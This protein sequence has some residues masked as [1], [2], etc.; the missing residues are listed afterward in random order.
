MKIFATTETQ[1]DIQ[2]SAISWTGASATSGVRNFLAALYAH[3]NGTSSHWSIKS[4]TASTTSATGDGGFIIKNTAGVEICFANGYDVGGTMKTNKCPNVFGDTV[5]TYG[6]GGTYTQN[7]VHLAIAPGGGVSA[8]TDR[9]TQ[10]ASATRFS[11]WTRAGGGDYGGLYGASSSYAYAKIVETPNYV[12]IRKH[13]V[14]GD[15]K[16]YNIG[17]FAG[18][19]EAHGNNATG[20]FIACAKFS[21]WTNSGGTLY[22]AYHMRYESSSNGHWIACMA[23]PPPTSTGFVSHATYT[24]NQ[25]PG[26][27]EEGSPTYN[28]Y[29][30][31]IF[32]TAYESTSPYDYSFVGY[33]PCILVG[34]EGNANPN[35]SS[36]LTSLNYDGSTFARCFGNN[37]QACWFVRDD[38]T[39]TENP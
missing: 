6:A 25:H 10:I 8:I 3:F 18:Q 2:F 38:G 16:Y 31:A 13:F 4:G 24:R 36:G 19:I 26:N 32:D 12:F 15:N 9:A 11:G 37:D 22:P 7:D 30:L 17:C 1:T 27:D 23:N 33:V 39:V 20:N 14:S 5:G 28:F 29:K 21:R 35:E 34:Q